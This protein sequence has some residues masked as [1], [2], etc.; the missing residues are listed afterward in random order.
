MQSIESDRISSLDQLI[1]KMSIQIGLL[2]KKMH[3]IADVYQGI[4]VNV[5][6]DIEL[7]CKK[8][9]T[10]TNNEQEIYLYDIY[11]ENIKNMMNRDRRIESL[12]KWSELL[13]QDMNS[14]LKAKEGLDKVKTFAKENPN[15]NV[16]NDADLVQKT[17]SVNL[18]QTLCEA[19]LFKVQ[20][21]LT[22]LWNATRPN[23]KFSDLI[24]TTYDKQGVPSSILKL[25]ASFLINPFEKASAPS[26]PLSPS[27][28]RVSY[29]NNAGSNRDSQLR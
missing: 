15:F 12:T 3:R 14:Q 18:M 9:G 10:S 17:Q 22:V 7:A 13:S 26:P 5:K 24:N 21:A 19:S 4:N 6:Q 20:S 2:A 28:S 16:N 29:I 25:P 8:H 23:Y 1:K 11:P 27:V